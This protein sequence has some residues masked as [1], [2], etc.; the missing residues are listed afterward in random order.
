MKCSKRHNAMRV[1]ALLAVVGS[2]LIVAYRLRA[3]GNAILIFVGAYDV[4]NKVTDDGA[5]TLMLEARRGDVAIVKRLLRIG[6][7]VQEADQ[8]GRVALMYAAEGGDIGTLTVLSRIEPFVDFRDKYGFTALHIA[9]MEGH[10]NA[11]SFLL[12]L[13]YDINKQDNNGMTALTH[14]I[15]DRHTTT[16]KVLLARDPRVLIKDRFGT[17]PHAFARDACR[18]SPSPEST[19]IFQKIEAMA[20]KEELNR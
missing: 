4:N 6:A 7:S 3:H 11:V 14:A 15:M 9:T 20:A 19:E 8:A 5:T 13:G 16:A 12:D 10:S 2:L 18:N 1:I 17:S